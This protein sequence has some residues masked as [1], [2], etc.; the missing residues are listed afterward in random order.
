[1]IWKSGH[2][3]TISPDGRA[4]VTVLLMPLGLG[5]VALNVT[6]VPA[7]AT[8]LPHPDMSATTADSE[9]IAAEQTTDENTPSLVAGFEL[10]P[11]HAPP[12]MTSTATLEI[13]PESQGDSDSVLLPATNVDTP[14][15]ST[16]S[17]STAALDYRSEA[18]FISQMT[19]RDAAPPTAEAVPQLELNEAAIATSPPVSSPTL[20]PAI[21]S[22][23]TPSCFS[24]C[25][26]A[27]PFTFQ[28]AAPAMVPEVGSAGVAVPQI[29]FVAPPVAPQFAPQ[30]VPVVLPTEGYGGASAAAVPIVILVMPGVNAAAGATAPVAGMPSVV[31]GTAPVMVY[32][33][34]PGAGGYPVAPAYIPQVL[35]GQVSQVV[36]TPVS[37]PSVAPALPSAAPA[38]IAPNTPP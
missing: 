10:S 29:P 34:P 4:M 9:W 22:P 36:P 7:S 18:E 23:A 38:A 14:T 15:L 26:P 2:L 6:A 28:P 13:Q 19:G 21:P 25:N 17:H 20:Q 12:V 33:V 32:V 31:P 1:M 24:E 3:V 8:P 37:L 11:V 16:Q 30:A 5:L 27:A 35:P